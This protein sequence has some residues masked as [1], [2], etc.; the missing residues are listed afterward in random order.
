MNPNEV[1]LEL[2][3]ELAASVRRIDDKLDLARDELAEI[4]GARIPDALATLSRE[5]A[6]HKERLNKLEEA[7]RTETAVAKPWWWFGQELIKPLIAAAVGAGAALFA[8]KGAPP[9]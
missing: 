2:F 5:H 9:P 1:A 7:N 4:R 3:R 6:D 8:L